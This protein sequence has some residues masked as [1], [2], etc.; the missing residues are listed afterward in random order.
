MII[1]LYNMYHLCDFRRTLKHTIN[2][3]KNKYY[4]TKFRQNKGNLKRH[5]K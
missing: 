2:A 4:G 5:G 3:G 1:V